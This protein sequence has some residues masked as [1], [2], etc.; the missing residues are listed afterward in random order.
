MKLHEADKGG[1][2]QRRDVHLKAGHSILGRSIKRV[3]HPT[4]RPQ[5]PSHTNYVVQYEDG[6]YE[7]AS[8]D[9][10]VEVFVAAETQERTANESRHWMSVS[11]DL[12]TLCDEADR[13]ADDTPDP[14]FKAW[15]KR[16]QFYQ[17][18]ARLPDDGE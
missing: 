7:N 9:F 5:E 15:Q 11:S 17:E 18:N 12:Q 14:M 6:E 2:L 3:L 16:F 4:I 8:A 13:L 1:Y 10:Q